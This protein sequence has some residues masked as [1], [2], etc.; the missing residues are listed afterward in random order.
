MFKIVKS[1]KERN[2]KWLCGYVVTRLRGYTVTW[3]PRNVVLR[4]RGYVH[5]VIWLLTR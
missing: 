1:L 4:L 3:L 2:G 5:M